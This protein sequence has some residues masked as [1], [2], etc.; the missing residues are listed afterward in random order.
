MLESFFGFDS[1]GSTQ[2]D[3]MYNLNHIWLLLFVVAFITILT[4]I[5]RKKSIKTQKI[6]LGTVGIAMIV[7]EIGRVV[8]RM[9]DYLQTH[10]TLE[11]WNWS[12]SISFQL[13][14]IMTWF[15]SINLIIYAFS[16]K[17]H[18]KWRV[19]AFNIMVGVAGLGGFLTFMYPDLIH[20]SRSILHWENVQ[21]IVQHTL[22]IFVPLFLV[23]TNK[24][25]IKLKNL[26]MPLAGVAGAAAIAMPISLWTD[27]NFMYMLEF[28]LLGD[29]GV[30]I[31]FPY[32]LFVLLGLFIV[33]DLIVYSSLIG[34][35]AL[36]RKLCK[37]KNE[38]DVI[39]VE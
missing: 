13:C 39:I 16:K 18:S 14:A 23:V 29:L 6:M 12:W 8:W 19:I 3:F 7:L 10:P 30:N 28:N 33:L 25:Q 35:K 37:L 22:L 4:L 32:H 2:L 38:D 17:E 24:V 11:G 5:F 20:E 26:W 1:Y 36:K 9:L 15:V 21:T 27:N 34:I 31:P